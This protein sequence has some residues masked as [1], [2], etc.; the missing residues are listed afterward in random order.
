MAGWLVGARSSPTATL[1]PATTTLHSKP[2]PVM[3]SFSSQGP[4][5]LFPEILKVQI[6]VD[7]SL[8]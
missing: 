4:N 1:T 7:Y 8:R 6:Q 5:L 3:A 2:A